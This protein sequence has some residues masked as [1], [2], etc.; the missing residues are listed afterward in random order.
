MDL[1]AS[2]LRCGRQAGEITRRCVVALL[3]AWALWSPSTVSAQLTIEPSSESAKDSS[4][5]FSAEDDALLNEIQ[6]GCFQYFWN[7]VGHPALLAKDK[8]TDSVCSTA[9]V[10]FQL[11]SLP[12]GVE[13][14]WITREQ[15]EER[16]E[17]ILRSLTEREDNKKYGIYLHY[18]DSGDGGLPD[19]TKTKHRYEIQASTVDHALLQAGSM[20]V[21]SYFGGKVAEAANRIIADAQWR[22]MYDEAAKYLTM[23]WRA[24]SDRGV[25]GPGEISK[26][27]WEWCSD[28]ERLIYFL[29]VGSPNEAQA[30]EPKTYYHLKRVVKEYKDLPPFVVSWNGSLFTYFFSSCWIN[31]KSYPADNPGLFGE[32]GP[33]VQWWENS[34]RAVV[35]HRERCREAASRFS[36]LGEN[37]WG[38]A[39]CSFRDDYLVHEVRPNIADKDTWLDGVTAPYAA[40]SSIMFAP[41]DCMAAL[42]EYRTLRDAKSKPVAWQDPE[43]GGYGFVDSFS[44]D[45]PHGQNET[46]GVDAGP[47]LLA[48]E[49]VR[50]GLIWQLFMKHE[51]AQRATA[52]LLWNATLASS[53]N[54]TTQQRK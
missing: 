45:P 24:K 51:V 16:A 52:R 47:L 14:G 20:T 49:N 50:T 12:I 35:T 25:D 34:R 32:D 36:T 33:A 2:R 54:I 38:L 5:K 6:K 21:A 30:L 23:G 18:I 31:Y 9:A 41:R 46:L 13:R 10:G 8:T 29:A 1:V 7:E 48:I 3:V 42:R 44:L 22:A 43:D 15:G 26:K 39:P 28:E 17:K 27:H 19:F 53:A 37:R 11:S 4:Y 40:G